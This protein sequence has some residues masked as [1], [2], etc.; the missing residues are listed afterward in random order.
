MPRTDA[1]E[2][3]GMDERNVEDQELEKALE[4]RLRAADDI[5]EIR[6]VYKVADAAVKERVGVLDLADGDAIRCGRFRVAKTA[7]ASRAVSFETDPT[8]RLTISLWSD[9]AS[10]K[11]TVV[12]GQEPLSSFRRDPDEPT[13]IRA[14]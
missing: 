11:T 2:Q 14:N 13:P 12:E 10:A 7:V 4:D 8:S 6:K 9:G 1:N 5:S 3:L